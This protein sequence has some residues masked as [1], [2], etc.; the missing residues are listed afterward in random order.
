MPQQVHLVDVIVHK[1]A[2]IARRRLIHVV[3]GGIMFEAS[4]RLARFDQVI[5]SRCDPVAGRHRDADVEHLSELAGLLPFFDD[6]LGILGRRIAPLVVAKHEPRLVLLQRTH[7]F[8][9]RLDRACDRFLGEDRDAGLRQLGNQQA[10][11]AERLRGHDG[12]ELLVCQKLLVAFINPWNA[13]SPGN[14]LRE[15]RADFRERDD[16][17]FLSHAGTRVVP[18]MGAL[19][20]ATDADK[21]DF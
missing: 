6:L 19:A 7:D 16:L 12:I 5:E 13:I 3:G 21:S 14:L 8:F 4:G 20:H 2:V 15:I 18:Q 10:V 11:P 1:A 9:P 17:A